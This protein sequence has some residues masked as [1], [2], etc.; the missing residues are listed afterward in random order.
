MTT[1][2]AAPDSPQANSCTIRA[3]LPRVLQW[4]LVGRGLS[5]PQILARDGR[6]GLLAINRVR[7]S[8]APDTWWLTGPNYGAGTAHAS[9]AEAKAAA[10]RWAETGERPG[11]VSSEP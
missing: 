1:A 2:H 8:D 5:N 11:G 10:E 9:Q 4:R 3:R 7:S 6:G